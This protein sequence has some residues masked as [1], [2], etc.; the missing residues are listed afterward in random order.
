MPSL[1]KFKRCD[2]SLS[3]TDIPY[4]QLWKKEWKQ[5]NF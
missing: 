4:H 5:L 2:P 1:V 3:L